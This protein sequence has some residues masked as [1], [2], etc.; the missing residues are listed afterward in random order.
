MSKKSYGVD[1]TPEQIKDLESKYEKMMYIQEHTV[2]TEE[3]IIEI[4]GLKVKGWLNYTDDGLIHKDIDFVDYLE[5][6]AKTLPYNVRRSMK[7]RD[8]LLKRKEGKRQ[9]KLNKKGIINE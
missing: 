1:I 5:Q 8:K 2:K 7:K 3:A 9:K 6:L 4:D